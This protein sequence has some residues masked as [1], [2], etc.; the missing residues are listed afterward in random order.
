[1]KSR[2]LHKRPGASHWFRLFLGAVWRSGLLSKAWFVMEDDVIHTMHGRETKHASREG[3]K[4]FQFCTQWRRDLLS[5]LCLISS[6][7]MISTFFFLL[8]GLYQPLTD[9][10]FPDVPLHRICRSW[11][12]VPNFIKLVAFTLSPGSPLLFP[13]PPSASPVLSTKPAVAS[14]ST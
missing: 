2:A 5:E 7:L 4:L 3:S 6:H 14:V 8:L 9:E 12:W 13:F 1:M 10:I 11:K